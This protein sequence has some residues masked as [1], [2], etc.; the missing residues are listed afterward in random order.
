MGWGLGS[1]LR[2]SLRAGWRPLVGLAL[3]IGLAGGALLTGVEAAR[4]TETAF[5][6]MVEATNAWDV[7]VNPD[8]GTDSALTFDMVAALPMVEQAGRLDGVSVVPENVGGFDELD[9]GFLV[10]ASDGI[11]GY[12]IGGPANLQGRLPDPDAADEVFLS[13]RAAE[14][15]G[16]EIGDHYT[17]RI[18]SDELFVALEQAVS[19]EEALALLNSDEFGERV[20]LKIV[21]IGAYF[22]EV[23]VDT[24]FSTGTMLVTPAFWEAHDEPS[25]GFYGAFVDLRPGVEVDDFRAAVEA[26]VPGQTIAFQTRPSIEAQAERAIRPQVAALR[27][28]TLVAGLIGLVI[29]AQAISRRLQLDAIAYAPLRALGLTERQRAALALTRTAVAATVGGLL[30]VAI[31]V[32]ASPIAP[33]G[34]ARDAEPTPGFRVEWAVVLGGAVLVVAAVMVIAVWPAIASTR[35]REPRRQRASASAW[36]AAAGFSPSVVAGTR[37]ALDPGPANDPTRSTLV[38]AATAVV[39]VEATLTFAASLDNFID[40]PRLYGTPWDAVVSVEGDTEVAPEDV[41]PLVEDVGSADEV[42]AYGLLTP[43]QVVLDGT[44]L[45]AISIAPS[46]EPIQPTLLAGRGPQAEDEVALGAVT[47]DHL[48]VD[49]GDTVR[50][51]RADETAELA[52]VGRV[53]LPAVS[54]YPGADKTSLGEGALLSPEGLDDWGPGFSPEGALV[55]LTDGTDVEALL[56]RVDDPSDDYILSSTPPNLPSDVQSLENVRSTP[57][58]LTGLLTVLIALTVV[59]ALGAAVRSRRRDLAVLRTFGFTRRQVLAAVAVQ[60]TLIALVGLLIGVPVGIVVGRLAWSEVIDRFGGLVDLVTPVG[61]VA[62]LS[63]AVVVLANLV[64]VVPGL[65]AARA[66]T[67]SI[68]RAE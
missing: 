42:E 58:V 10:G 66:H 30:A 23:V 12:E 36:V 21:G 41:D 57:L 43:G 1:L 40:S 31:A 37:F 52:V 53:V 2:A 56:A 59:H 26:T 7:L 48:G 62:L 46:P 20:D 16:L 50:V 29:V 17:G 4:R 63:L 68:L 5:D 47:L 54:A 28:F 11:A 55:D 8:E 49:V 22:D 67:A 19:E 14:L 35:V 18:L 15:N 25:A 61:G 3:L 51:T 32:T 64:G 33:V 38:G 65:R 60:A 24:G 44:S 27:V 13:A 6:R 9:E 39:L 34:V 45:P